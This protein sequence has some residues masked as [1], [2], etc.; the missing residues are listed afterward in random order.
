MHL[1]QRNLLLSVLGGVLLWVAWP[2]SPFTLFIFIAWVPLLFVAE[3]TGSWK[4]FFGYTYVHMLIWNVLTTWWVAK[5]SLAGGLSAFFANSL[6]MCIPWLLQY[7]TLK[8]IKGFAGTLSIVFYWLT[9]EYIHQNWDLS[10]PWLTLGNA[11]AT[12]PGWV[13]WYEYTGTSGGSL[14]VLLSN[15]LVFHVLKL[16]REE[17]RTIRYFKNAIAWIALL[18]IPILFSFFIKNS[19]TLLHNKYNVVVVQPNIDPWDEK[20]E[21]GKEEAQLQKLIALSQKEIDENTALVVWPETAIPIGVNESKLK[22]NRFLVPL[23]GFIKNNPG[24]NLLTGLEGYREFDSRVSRYARKIPGENAYYE[25]Y[26]SAVLLDSQHIQIYHK[27]KLVP[28]PEVLPW[29]VSFLG[30]VFEK[31]GGTAGGY[32]RDTA[33]HNFV[34]TNNTFTIT[35]AICYESIY[36]DYLADFNRKGSNLICVITNDGWW[37]N[38]QGYK[39]HE[40]YARLRAIESRKWVARSA[41]TGISCFIDPYGNIVQ[42][43]GWNKKGALKQTV[44]A[45]VTETFFTKNGDIISKIAGVT[46]AVILILAV[47]NKCRPKS[48]IM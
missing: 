2:T 24:I 14:W 8:N 41:N 15:I 11:F 17:G 31:F 40:N 29:F 19:L 26:N 18:F 28:G 21:A 39:Q 6:V 16:Y 9:F 42:Q 1:P 47:I 22:E 45:F 20:F 23:W 12:Y 35:P 48:R 34:T 36:G 30:P 37:G 25:A 46:A 3:N 10:W 43:L 5:A 38:T 44:A 4:K 7:F 33:A 27:S 13:Q 32:A